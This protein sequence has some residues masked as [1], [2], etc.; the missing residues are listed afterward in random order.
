MFS[1]ES[2]QNTVNRIRDMC[3]AV[4]DIEG[5][6]LVG[7][8]GVEFPDRCADV[9]LSIVVDPLEKTREVWEALNEQFR[10]AFDLISFGIG[11]YGENDFISILLP[12]GYLEVDVGVTSLQ[13]LEAKRD[14][15]RILFEKQNKILTKMKQSMKERKLT[16][17]VRFVRD[18]MST[19]GHYVRTFAVA[20]NRKQPFRANK[21]LEDLRNTAVKVSA[22]QNGKIAEH[23]RD[24]DGADHHFRSQRAL[25]YPKS[26][27]LNDLT[28]AF[29]HVF[30]LFFG[31]AE[32]TDP[33][34]KDIVSLR[35]QLRRLLE[36]FSIEK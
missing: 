7:S 3:R 18:E 35:T 14:K 9:D 12:Q 10:E 32:E 1:R 11:I 29:N 22:C 16:D 25:T 8:G 30:D 4:D 20:V 13:N 19:V 31:L 2:R 26:I 27:E 33:Q 17:P 36:D 15:W 21:E 28:D 23:F 24:V 34:N 5:V 6:L